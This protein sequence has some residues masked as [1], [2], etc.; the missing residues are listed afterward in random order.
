MAI[1][2]NR[3][4]DWAESRFPDLIEK[5]KEIRINSIFEEDENYHLWCSPS[6]GKKKRKFGVFHCFKTDRKGSLVNLVMLVDNC[7]RDDALAVLQNETSVRVMEAQLEEFFAAQEKEPETPPPIVE[8]PPGTLKIS[9]LPS[10]NWWRLRAEEHLI[11]RKIPIDD[12]YICTEGEYK[13]R[14]IIPYYDKTGRLIYWN[15]RHIGKS[16]AKYRGPE[17][18][19]GVGKADVVYMPSWPLPGSQVHLCEGEFNAKALC[20]SG[21]NGGACGGKSMSETQAVM[22]KDY[23]IVLC[24]DRDKAGAK[25]TAAMCE[26]VASIESALKMQSKLSYVRPPLGYNDWNE[27]YVTLGPKIVQA[28][29]ERSEKTLDFQAPSGMSGDFFALNDL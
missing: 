2:F 7:D 1:D 26:K 13:A 6:G 17:K 12:L 5:G 19:I 18:E 10:S 23:R 9:D 3:F 25:G 14:I 27:M 16:K 21:L 11:A 15:G 22:L 29:I 24:L 4:R 28:Y 20:L 8:F